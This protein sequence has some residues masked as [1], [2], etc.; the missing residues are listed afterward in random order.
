MHLHLWSLWPVLNEAVVLGECSHCGL[1]GHDGLQSWVAVFFPKG[2]PKCCV[3]SQPTPNTAAVR[4]SDCA[5]ILSFICDYLSV[6]VCVYKYDLVMHG[7]T[8]WLCMGINVRKVSI[9]CLVAFS[10]WDV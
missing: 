6:C 3:F 5:N 8:S 10:R 1:G 2:V 9:V 4:V 7:S